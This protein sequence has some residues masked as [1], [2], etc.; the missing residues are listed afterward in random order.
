MIVVSRSRTMPVPVEFIWN[1]LADFDHLAVW[2]PNADHTCWMDEPAADG[3]MVGRARRVQAGRVVLIETITAWDAPTRLAYD[4]A[5]LPP[6]VRTAV[7]EWRLRVDT[8]AR[9]TV[10][11]ATSVDCGARPP[12]QLVA[13][14]VA[15]RLARAS[16]Q[17]LDGLAAHIAGGT[18]G[19]P[20]TVDPS[21]ATP[22]PAPCDRSSGGVH[23]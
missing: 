15:R 13:R 8:P 3:E 9:T 19:P 5:G 4:L 23:P 11:L 12:R 22:D 1:V 14:L 20:A 17:M 16:D 10:T 2:A 7:N 6:I 18:A 21:S